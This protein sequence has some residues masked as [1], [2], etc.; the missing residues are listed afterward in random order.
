MV[1]SFRVGLWICLPEPPRRVFSG[2]GQGCKGTVEYRSAQSARGYAAKVPCTPDP[3]RYA[4]KRGGPEGRS[5]R[6]TRYERMERKHGFPRPVRPHDAGPLAAPRPIARQRR[7]QDLQSAR[8]AG[9]CSTSKRSAQRRYGAQTSG[10]EAR[11]GRDSRSEARR[12]ARKPGPE[13]SGGRR[14]SQRA[15]QAPPVHATKRHARQARHRT[16]EHLRDR[17]RQE[18]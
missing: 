18:R 6:L 16:G 9:A 14:T 8:A 1:S 10:I 4:S 2:V 12:E 15:G 11:Q 13:R 5:T 17:R 3:F 7:A